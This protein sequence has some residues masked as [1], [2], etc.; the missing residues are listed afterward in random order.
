MTPE[1]QRIAIA[2][3]CGI[4]VIYDAAGPKDRPEAWKTGYFTPT[5]AKQRRRSWPSSG[6][7]K[8]I[9]DYLNDLN[10]CH[11]MEKL[12]T[13][14]QWVSYWSFLEPL[15]CRPNNTSI[16][17]ATAAQRCEAFLRTIGKWEETK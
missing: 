3:A 12:L 8:I 1:Q 5:A 14:E 4:D 10:A 9:P 7:V 11:E 13:V 16:L 6:V 15:A 17:H 2:E